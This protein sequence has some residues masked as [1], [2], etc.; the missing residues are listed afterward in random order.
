MLMV[1]TWKINDGIL[2]SVLYVMWVDG[3]PHAKPGNEVPSVTTLTLDFCQ[4]LSGIKKL[5][6]FTY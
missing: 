2:G 1:G 4:P 5:K 6:I 3:K